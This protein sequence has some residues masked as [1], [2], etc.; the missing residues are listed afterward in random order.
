MV[1]VER[2]KQFT[3]IP[4]ESAWVLKD[5]LPPPTWPTHGNVDLKDLQVISNFVFYTSMNVHKPLLSY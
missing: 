1:S 4:S 5:R 2:I 3:N